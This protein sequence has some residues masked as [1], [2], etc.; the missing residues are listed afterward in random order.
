MDL[1]DLQWSVSYRNW[2]PS[3]WTQLDENGDRAFANYDIWGNA[4]IDG[5]MR[6]VRYGQY[7][8]DSEELTWFVEGE[9]LDGT[10]VPGLVPVGH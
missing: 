3:G 10:K 9:L 8:A 2:G 5:E 7:D 4:M 1:Y 6:F